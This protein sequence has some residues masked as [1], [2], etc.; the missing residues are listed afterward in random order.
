[1][2]MQ[3]AM[4]AADRL[5]QNIGKVVVGKEEVV[6]LLLAGLFGNGHVLL[7]DVPGTGKTLLAK[8]LSVSLGGE[9]RRV[10]FTPDLLPSDLSGINF[11]NQKTGEFEF[12]AGPL[13]THVLLADEINRATPRTQSSLLEC[14]E[15]RQVTID[16]VTRKLESPF[17]VMATQNPV[18]NQGTFPLPEA[19]LD[20]FLMRISMGYP[21][22]EEGVDI[23]LRFRERNPLEELAPVVTAAEI[24]EA[25]RLTAE[26]HVSR[27]LLA[28][29]VRLA[30]ATRRNP[31]VRLGASPRAA[32]A[33]LRAA[34]GLALLSGRDFVTPDDIKLVAIPVL[35]HRLL[36]HHALHVGV[37]EAPESAVIRQVLGEVEVPAE[38]T[39]AG[40]GKRGG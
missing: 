25:Q 20:R 23:L 36:L 27:D 6:E 37:G 7:E 33:L 29:I 18:D 28:Y 30:E 38:E 4:N 11:Y 2:N 12:R 40:T 8:A 9:F 35:A 31:G 13:F 34:Q 15:E 32:M 39:G 10:Q 1:M 16:G 24:A 5:R 3:D 19:Q 14:M 22:L 17:F 21:S 26:I